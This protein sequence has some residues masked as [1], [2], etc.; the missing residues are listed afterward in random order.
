M[1]QPIWRT[2]DKVTI[3]CAGC[4]VPGHV[5]LASGNGKSLMLGFDT[6]LDGHVSAMPVL[7]DDAGEFRSIV[8]GVSV[9]LGDRTDDR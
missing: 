2:G 9:T 5:I 8:N 6:I 4:T 1:I 3:R 7:A